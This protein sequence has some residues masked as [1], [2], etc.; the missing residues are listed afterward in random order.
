M[1]LNPTKIG[2][3]CETLKEAVSEQEFD[4]LISVDETGIIYIA[5]GMV[6]VEEDEPGM[7]EYPLYF[8]PFCGT[9]LQTPEEVEAKSAEAGK[10][11]PGNS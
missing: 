1:A 3:C 2:T 4:P 11:D 5:V 7:V 10:A 6:D 9:K 8:C